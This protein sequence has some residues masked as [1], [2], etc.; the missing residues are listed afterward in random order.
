[1]K[2]QNTGK[3]TIERYLLKQKLN[4]HHPKNQTNPKRDGL[5]AVRQEIYWKGLLILKRMCCAS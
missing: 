2:K 5:N 4:A 3:Y 1:M